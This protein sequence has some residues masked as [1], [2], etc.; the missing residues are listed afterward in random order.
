[1]S[2]KDEAMARVDAAASDTWKVYMREAVR[3]TCLRMNR[4]TSDDVFDRVDADPNALVTHELRAFG[5]VML[6][7]AHL[8]WCR[9]ADVAPVPSRRESLHYSPRAVWESLIHVSA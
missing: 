8:G 6:R 7:A 1:M 2:A 4:F 9:K 5:P 3:Q